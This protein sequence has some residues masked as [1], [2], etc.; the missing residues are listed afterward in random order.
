[1]SIDSTVLALRGVDAQHRE[2]MAKL[3]QKLHLQGQALDDQF[4]EEVPTHL[5]VPL[6]QQCGMSPNGHPDCRETW[7]LL[8]ATADA[9]GQAMAD[10]PTLERIPRFG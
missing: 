6:W 8:L 3:A 9:A 2:H 5:P 10:H 7:A 1:M 4:P